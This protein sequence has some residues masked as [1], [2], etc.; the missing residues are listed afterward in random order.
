[1]TPSSDALLAKFVDH[2]HQEARVKLKAL[3]DRAR[4]RGLESAVHIQAGRPDRAVARCAEETGSDWVVVGAHGRSG[5]RSLWIGSVA[6]KIVRASPVSVLCVR[7]GAL[8]GKGETIVF[9]EDF[10]SPE[11]RDEVAALARSLGARIVA[12]HGIE[13]PPAAMADSSFS[14]PPALLESS[15]AEMRERMEASADDYGPDAETVVSLG[16]ASGALCDQALRRNASLVV[17]GTA[18]RKGVERWMLGSVAEK[19]LRHASCSV[20]VLRSPL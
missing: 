15:M 11:R 10:G 6:E 1:L 17:T 16:D 14:P 5:I 19:T 18:S 8:P 7:P 2:E 20:L 9:G 3:Q 12:V 4:E 13:L